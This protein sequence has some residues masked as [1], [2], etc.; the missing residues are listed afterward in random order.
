MPLLD[1]KYL[2]REFHAHIYYQAETRASAQ[3][4][5]EK[6]SELAKGRLSLSTL[7]DG[8]RGPHVVSMFGVVIPCDDLSEVLGF[9][10]LNH[11]G[12]S[13]LIHPETDHSVL[14]H[15]FHALWLGQPQPLDLSCLR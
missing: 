3:T 4:L 8:P 1:P 13:V 12:H 7:S 11:G 15:T 9:L 10:M 5:R 14:D 6:I 2:V